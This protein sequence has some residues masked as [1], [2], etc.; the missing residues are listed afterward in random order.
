MASLTFTT[1]KHTILGNLP[2]GTKV[3]STLLT[4]ADA[5]ADATQFTITPLKKV[6]AFIP[7]F[8]TNVAGAATTVFAAGTLANQISIDPPV[9]TIA[10]AVIEIISFGV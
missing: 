2:N 3:V 9:G 1:T 8:K 4:T 10:T 5:G 7:T 6:I